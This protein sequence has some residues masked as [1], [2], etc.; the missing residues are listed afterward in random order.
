MVVALRKLQTQ[1]LDLLY[2]WR[3]SERVSRWMI[4]DGPISVAD[5]ARWFDRALVDGPNKVRIISYCAIDCGVLSWKAEGEGRFTFGIYVIAELANTRGV[6]RS[7]LK[8]L[9][10]GLFAEDQTESVSAEVLKDNRRAIQAYASLG[11]FSVQ[12]SNR[13]VSRMNGNSELL[14]MRIDRKTWD[15]LSDS[16]R[17][18][19]LGG[20]SHGEDEGRNV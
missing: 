3:N 1:D 17:F 10:D 5:H 4:N 19:V 15:Q 12:G 9:L 2:G 16:P 11:F 7:A 6:G 13:L 14:E 20:G 18:E 8:L